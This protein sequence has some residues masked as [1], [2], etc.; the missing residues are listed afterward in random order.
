MAKRIFRIYG[1]KSYRHSAIV[2]TD[3]AF[4][5]IIQVIGITNSLC[6]TMNACLRKEIIQKMSIIFK[7]K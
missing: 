7:V 2:V 5:R 6:D 3:Y 4:H 1:N